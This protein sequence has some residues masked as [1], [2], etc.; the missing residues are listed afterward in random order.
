MGAAGFGS[1][2]DLILFLASGAWATAVGFGFLPAL[3]KD[4]EA[5]AKWRLRFGRALKVI[6][7]IAMAV[8]LAA[9]AHRILNH[10]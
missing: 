3:G 4:S 5:R 7:P 9:L 1:Y 10:T 2:L 6:G 8:A